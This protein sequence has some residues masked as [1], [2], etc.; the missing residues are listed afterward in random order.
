VARLGYNG[1]SL[2]TVGD[3]AFIVA[4]TGIEAVPKEILEGEY[5]VMIGNCTEEDEWVDHKINR[6]IVLYGTEIDNHIEG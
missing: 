1:Y 6:S 4:P 5:D 3:I 2:Y